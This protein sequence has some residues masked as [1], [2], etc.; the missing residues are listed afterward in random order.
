MK[1]AGVV[2]S[3]EAEQQLVSLYDYIAGQASPA[4]A[5]KF[6][7]AIVD[8]CESLGDMPRQETARGDLRPG[9]RTISYRRRVVIAYA[10][11]K[12][13]LTIVGVYYGGQDYESILRDGD[14]T[15]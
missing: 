7:G 6:V 3:P 8:R 10:V 11:E 9:L 4:V 12:P 1:R 5:T 15:E 2:F 13:T 14:E